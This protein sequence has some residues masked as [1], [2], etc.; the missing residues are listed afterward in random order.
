MNRADEEA[1]FK[2][3]S[4]DIEE[5]MQARLNARHKFVIY[6]NSEVLHLFIAWHY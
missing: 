5:T 3:G 4:E 1:M 6:P 2:H